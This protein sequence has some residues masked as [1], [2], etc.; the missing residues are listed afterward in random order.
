MCTSP[1][2]LDE[3]NDSFVLPKGT[4][5][6]DWVESSTKCNEC[7]RSLL[8]HVGGNG[9]ICTKGCIRDFKGD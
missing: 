9:T 8:I 3:G 5:E 4:T 1:E 7:G 6:C 2:L